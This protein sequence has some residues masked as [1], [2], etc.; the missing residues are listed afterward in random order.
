MDALDF[1]LTSPE[2]VERLHFGA[3]AE[4][5]MPKANIERIRRAR[6]TTA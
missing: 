5:P 6:I 4:H 1:A 3:A 2:H